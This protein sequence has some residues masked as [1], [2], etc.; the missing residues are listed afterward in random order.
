MYVE[1]CRCLSPWLVLTSTQTCPVQGDAIPTRIHVSTPSVSP[2]PSPNPAVQTKARTPSKHHA[3]PNCKK[4]FKR[5]QE[6]KRHVLSNLPHCIHCP[7]P[8]CPWTGNRQYNF[9][10]H[11]EVHPNFNSG[12]ENERKES[13]IYDPKKLVESMASGTLA[14]GKAADIARSMV[15][16]KFPKPDKA[17]VKVNVWGSRRKLCKARS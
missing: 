10:K 8:R 2:V 12:R 17:G 16:T 13:Q 7:F 4:K 14:F 15:K 5:R 11:I 9:M 3:C 1:Y 6:L